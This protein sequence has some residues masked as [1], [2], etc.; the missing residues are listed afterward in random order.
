MSKIIE[1]IKHL[2]ME[3]P[4]LRISF[5]SGF[6]RI[7]H[8]GH[9]RL[10]RFAKETAD[11]LVVGIIPES[12]NTENSKNTQDRLE[13]IES[14]ISVDFADVI[15]DLKVFLQEL[16][17]DFVIKGKEHEL[18][19]NIEQ[20]VLDAYGGIVLFTSGVA[21]VN[22]A[23]ITP[24]S[25]FEKIQLIYPQEFCH[26]HNIY[27][28]QL[29]DIVDSFS[30]LSVIVIGDII[31]DEYIDCAP[32]GMS[33][34]DPTIVVTPLKND[35]YLGGAGIVAAHVASLGAQVKFFSIC[36]EDEIEKFSKEKLS[37][38]NVENYLFVDKSRPTSLKQR[39]RCKGKTLLR[40][41]HLRQ[42][43]ISSELALAMLT[44]IEQHLAQADLLIFSDF[45]YGCL[46]QFFVEK[47][48]QRAQEYGVNI[49]ADSQ[50]SSQV[51][52]ISRF[53]NAI[54]L[55]P[56]EREARLATKDFESGLVVLANKLREKASCENVV[57][58]LGEAGALVQ[59]DSTDQIQALNTYA[60]D[61]AG[62]G[63][64][65]LVG[66]SLAL[67]SQAN[68]WQ[69][70]CIGSIVAGVQVSREG[71]IPILKDHIVRQIRKW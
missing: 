60:V 37:Q 70:T 3:N 27:S 34:E 65:F 59:S 17:P 49:S 47:L 21:D 15:C 9:I 31:V 4:K 2:R 24:K 19:H 44:A 11:I 38:Y 28:K 39:F 66:S 64:S 5:V 56:T 6:F 10:L 7:I 43:A 13:A 35:K 40:V 54:L 71:N 45:N 63:D 52:D 53:T 22:I 8:V 42:H 50:S 46:P 23:E 41:S 33:Q 69:A 67:A 16:K 25:P 51:G 30:N 48:S 55:T 14:V 32:L 61:P 36:G 62:G 18:K 12:D 20:E 68:I 1:K 57:I 58:T 29:L 26:R